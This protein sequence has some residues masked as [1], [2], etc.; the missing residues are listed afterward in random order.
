MDQFEAI[1]NSLLSHDNNIRKQAEAAYEQAKAQPDVLVS[2]LIFLLRRQ[3][4]P[5]PIRSMCALLLRKTIMHSSD[6]MQ[7][8]AP[9]TGQ[10]L[11]QQL[12][13]CIQIESQRSIRKKVCDA[14]GQLGII[15]LEAD[16]AN[17][18]PEL[19][20]FMLQSTKSGNVNMHEAALSIFNALS[21]FMCDKSR[22]RCVPCAVCRAF[23]GR[24]RALLLTGAVAYLATVRSR[25]L[26]VPL[27]SS[28][29]RCSSLA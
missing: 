1:I 25:L 28:P 16:F 4:S 10:T 20:P 18:W 17:G 13:E 12:L 22:S 14:V 9:Q 26:L 11:K 3:E 7:K 21:D 29:L 5:E 23:F 8:V 6:L 19:L 2:G 27:A 15:L 24:R